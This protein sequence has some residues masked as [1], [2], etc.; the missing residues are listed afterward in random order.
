MYPS[1]AV[2]SSTCRRRSGYS[3]RAWKST[4]PQVRSVTPTAPTI[5]HAAAPH[6]RAAASQSQRGQSTNLAAMPVPRLSPARAG[7][8]RKR[9]ASAAASAS[10]IVTFPV[11]TAAFTDGQRRASG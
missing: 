4:S 8:S 2:A 10:G 3:S 1:P 5:V 11:C 7:R 6:R 9:Q